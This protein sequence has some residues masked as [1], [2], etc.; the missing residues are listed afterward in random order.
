MANLVTDKR[1]DAKI[2]CGS[3]MPSIQEPKFLYKCIPFSRSYWGY[4][5]REDKIRFSTAAELL[6]GNDKKEFDHRWESISPSFLYLAEEMKPHYDAL[7]LKS[8]I[9]SLGQSPNRRCW[10]E[11]CAGGGVRYEFEYDHNHKDRSYVNCKSVSYADSKIFNLCSF[12]LKY[13]TNDDVKSLFSSTA[14]R[15]FGGNA[16]V[17]NWIGSGEAKELTLDH[18]SNEI[19]FK[20][21][22][23]FR[24]EDEY[25][26]IHL[27]EKIGSEELKVKLQD[28]KISL[29]EIGLKLT[30][31]ST[32]DPAFV[33]EQLPHC[34]IPI[35][36][37]T[38]SD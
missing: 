19:P 37:I 27:F 7:Y 29:G 9:L 16:T 35:S 13:S 12:F 1:C 28:Q 2:H 25:R 10:A 30:R 4:I 36:E 33:Q 11:Y 15:T 3:A 22:T 24:F 8:G 6:T 17:L 34:K 21:T 23:E 18:A 31:I 20:K 5:V 38:F 14:S 26:F 32:N